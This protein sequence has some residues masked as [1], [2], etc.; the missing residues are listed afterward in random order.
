MKLKRIFF[1]FSVFDEYFPFLED[2]SIVRISGISNIE[3]PEQIFF[4]TKSF[5]EDNEVAIITRKMKHLFSLKFPMGSPFIFRNNSKFIQRD[6]NRKLEFE[7][8]QVESFSKESELIIESL[9]NLTKSSKVLNNTN[10]LTDILQHLNICDSS[11]SDNTAYHSFCHKENTSNK[12]EFHSDQSVY[13]S[14]NESRTNIDSSLSLDL[15]ATSTP[16]RHNNTVNETSESYVHDQNLFLST[17]EDSTVWFSINRD[18]IITVEGA[19]NLVSDN[20]S[21]ITETSDTLFF[22]VN[23]AYNN[24]KKVILMKIKDDDK[25]GTLYFI[26]Y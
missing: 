5:I 12:S 18:T 14:F 6:I 26:H 21:K 20:G 15:I 24:L 8:S 2:E 25:T 22:S 23:E 11:S 16:K 4:I 9:D 7:V 19:K 10:N 3:Y 1:H 13:H 17:T